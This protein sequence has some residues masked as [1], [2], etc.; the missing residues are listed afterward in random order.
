MTERIVLLKSP[1]IPWNI[2]VALLA[3]VYISFGFY[4]KDKIQEWILS[5]NRKKDYIYVVIAL[6]LITFCILNYS[7]DIPF[8]YFDMKP[9]Y[10]KELVSAVIIPCAFGIVIV[11]AVYWMQKYRVTKLLRYVLRFLGRITIPI[12]FMHIPVNKLLAF[13][14]LGPLMYLL[15]GIGIPTILTLLL[16]RYKLFRLLFACSIGKF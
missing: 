11:R 13:L 6:C 8:Y 10:Y 1:G 2:D 5:E 9:V 15:L 3:L 4:H 7:R 14:N 16:N 12:M